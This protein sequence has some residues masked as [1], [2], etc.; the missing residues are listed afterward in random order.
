VRLRK[1]LSDRQFGNLSV[2]APVAEK[3]SSGH[4][5]W[6]CFCSFCK[7]IKPVVGTLLTRKCRPITSC[8]GRSRVNRTHGACSGR[9]RRPTY[10]SYRAMLSRTSNQKQSN[11]RWYADVGVAKRWMGKRGYER[12]VQDMGERPTGTTLGRKLD[13]GMYCKRRCSWQTPE[14]QRAERERKLKVFTTGKGN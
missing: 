1:D 2:I 4:T 12:F 8:C 7:Q 14:Q 3:S 6:F 10:V 5:V 11:Y 13:S 9:K